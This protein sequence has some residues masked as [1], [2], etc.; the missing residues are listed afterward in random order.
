MHWELINVDGKPGYREA[1]TGLKVL[2]ASGGWQAGG[3]GESYK[4]PSEAILR[5][6]RKLRIAM[7]QGA[8]IEALRGPAPK[9]QQPLRS[10]LG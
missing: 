6:E 2:Q 10:Q 5:A 3:V 1:H 8:V 9:I 7:G 4:T